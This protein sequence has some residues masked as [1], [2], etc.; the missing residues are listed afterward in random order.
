M[1]PPKRAQKDTRPT[2]S[3]YPPRRVGVPLGGYRSVPFTQAVRC[4]AK[5]MEPAALA[6]QARLGPREWEYL[7]AAGE[8]REH[9][10][11]PEDERPGDQL[12]QRVMSAVHYGASE[13]LLP[14]EQAQGLAETLRGLDYL[15]AW[16]VIWALQWR[17]DFLAGGATIAEGDAWW[18]LAHRRQHLGETLGVGTQGRRSA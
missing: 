5:L 4:W 17:H 3:V 12:A 8:G 18:T 15:H 10:F 6:L 1:P 16:A 9:E 2:M 7:A 13:L 14:A 11:D